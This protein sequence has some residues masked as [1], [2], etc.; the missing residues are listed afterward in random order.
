MAIILRPLK[1]EPRTLA[2]HD[3]IGFGY[4]KEVVVDPHY[5]VENVVED[6]EPLVIEEKEADRGIVEYRPM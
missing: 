2:D 6:L 1:R 3:A 5:L 4:G